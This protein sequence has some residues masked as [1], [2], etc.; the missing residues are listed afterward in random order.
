MDVL[1]V[2]HKNYGLLWEQLEHWKN[3][4][5]DCRRHL[6]N[7]IE[8]HP[9]FVHEIVGADGVTHGGTIDFLLKNA[10]S[11]S[12]C[13]I[14]SDFFW[15][16]DGILNWAEDLLKHYS[17]IGT[18]LW[19]DATGGYWRVH[20]QREWLPSLPGI[21]VKR[22]MAME[23]TFVVTVPEIYACTETGWRIRQ[24]L[25]DEKLKY[26]TFRGFR[27]PER[28]Q[29]LI[30]NEQVDAGTL[31]G[32]QEACF[33]GHPLAPMGVHLLAGSW[34]QVSCNGAIKYLVEGA[35]IRRF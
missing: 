22:K 5:P 7:Y 19:H 21:F 32:I 11:E 3:T 29:K 10:T 28:N 20:P 25:V 14:D 13:I 15:L 24:R 8:G 31:Q 9:V 12:V 35:G 16:R 2:I 17:V 6:P 26:L 34:R 1:L 33:Y 23:Q 30:P 4:P 27:Y 18:Q